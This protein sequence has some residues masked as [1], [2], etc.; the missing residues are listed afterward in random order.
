MRKAPRVV[1]QGAFEYL[2]AVARSV[3]NGGSCPVCHQNRQPWCSAVRLS[4]A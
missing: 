4:A 2:G 3:R 1:P